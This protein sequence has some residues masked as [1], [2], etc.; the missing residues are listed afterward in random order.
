MTVIRNM[1]DALADDDF[2]GAREAL[3][4][5]LAQ[6]IS[7]TNYVSNADI[8][9]NRYHNPNDESDL[10]DYDREYQV[11]TDAGNDEDDEYNNYDDED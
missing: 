5:T 4:T 6:Y 7:G 10:L 2:S 9:G 1:I 8:F 3:K 11:N